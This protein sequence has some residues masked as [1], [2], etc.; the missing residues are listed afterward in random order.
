MDSLVSKGNALIERLSTIA[1]DTFFTPTQRNSSGVVHDFGLIADTSRSTFNDR[2][3]EHIANQDLAAREIKK[4]WKHSINSLKA[5]P[6]LRDIAEVSVYIYESEG[7]TSPLIDWSIVSGLQ[8]PS[9]LPPASASNICLGL[10]EVVASMATRIVYHEQLGRD[11][12]ARLIVML[13][14]YQSPRYDRQYLGEAK[15]AV[16]FALEHRINIIHLAAGENPDLWLAN[17][18]SQ[19]GREPVNVPDVDLER[20]LKSWLPQT[21]TIATQHSGNRKRTLPSLNGQT[22]YLD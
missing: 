22:L 13:S 5:L 3:A 14:D 7:I 2:M 18:L 6:H 1:T 9:E 4:N 17:L 16:S 12:E 8:V 19:P 11:V 21:M 15:K 20:L 10:A